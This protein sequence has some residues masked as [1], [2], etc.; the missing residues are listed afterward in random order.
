[1]LA[2]KNSRHFK[3]KQGFTL[4]EVLI[5][6][7][8][9][10]IIMAV[11]LPTFRSVAVNV[12]LLE[13]AT[14]ETDMVVDCF[15]RL[16]GDLRGLYIKQIPEYQKPEFNS[17]PDPYRFV[18][19]TELFESD[20]VP[21]LRFTSLAHLP[22]GGDMRNGVA[23]ITYYVDR[24]EATGLKI[25]KRADR[26]KFEEEFEKSAKDPVLMKGLHSLE[27][28]YYDAEG[29]D[30]DAWDSESDMVGYGTPTSISVKMAIGNEEANNQYETRISLPC[31]RVSEAD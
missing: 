2:V 14:D 23:E 13:E 1:M 27:F 6:I 19:G 21:I 26:L 9:F 3:D 24:D 4:L 30:A 10:G 7:A 11:V 5:A 16:T 22:I 12:K 18:G 15:A 8:I 28:S 17:D 20:T 29:E 31:I 25:L